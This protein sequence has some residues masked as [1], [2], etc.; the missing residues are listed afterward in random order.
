MDLIVVI[1]RSFRP[2]RKHAV[3]KIWLIATVVARSVVCLCVCL[4]VCWFHG[5][6]PR[7]RM[8]RSSAVWLTRVGPM[9]HVLDEGRDPTWMGFFFG[10]GGCSARWKALGVSAAVYAAN[11]IIHSSIT[12]QYAMRPFVKIIWPLVIVSYGFTWA[13][14]NR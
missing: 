12:A 7:K 8:N 1:I 9:N 13:L 6:S 4:S 5:F 14:G 3:H 11:R 10:G 2:H